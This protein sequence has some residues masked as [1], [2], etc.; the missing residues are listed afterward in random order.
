MAETQSHAWNYMEI[1]AI[2][3]ISPILPIKAVLASTTSENYVWKSFHLLNTD[4]LSAYTFEWAWYNFFPS[5]D[6]GQLLKQ[7][8]SEVLCRHPWTDLNKPVKQAHLKRGPFFE[9]PH[10]SWFIQHAATSGRHHW[11]LSPVVTSRTFLVGEGTNSLPCF[12]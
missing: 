11:S 8:S 6:W 10:Q 2:P 5:S 9:P 1:S 3:I 12:V 7:A 4:K